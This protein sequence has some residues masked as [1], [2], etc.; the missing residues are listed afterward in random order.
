MKYN[1]ILVLGTVSM[2]QYIDGMINPASVGD[3]AEFAA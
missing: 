2:R 1:E 3:V